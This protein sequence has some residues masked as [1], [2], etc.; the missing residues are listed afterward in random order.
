MF[1]F[2]FL[3]FSLYPQ[4]KNRIKY[5]YTLDRE[6]KPLAAD[7]V[8]VTASGGARGAHAEQI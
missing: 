4:C 5:S 2:L 1:I 6:E 3:F 7:A 8:R